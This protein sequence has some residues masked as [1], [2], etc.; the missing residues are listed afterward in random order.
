MTREA[1]RFPDWQEQYLAALL[2][3]APSKVPQRVH[4][5]RAAIERRFILIE[6]GAAH[7]AERKAI[8][9]AIRVLDDLYKESTARWRH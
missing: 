1:F 8:Y 6:N 5:A 2:E 4:A 9:D 7:K 3:T